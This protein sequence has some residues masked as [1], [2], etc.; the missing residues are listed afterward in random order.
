MATALGVPNG[1]DGIGT[2]LDVL[3]PTDRVS[4]SRSA[5]MLRAAA[6]AGSFA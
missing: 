5:R 3:A 6:S 1:A 4:P 2:H